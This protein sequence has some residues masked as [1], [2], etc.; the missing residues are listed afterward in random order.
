M[1]LALPTVHGLGNGAYEQWLWTHLRRVV[2]LRCAPELAICWGT[3]APAGARAVVYV[4]KDPQFLARPEVLHSLASAESAA[5]DV[6]VR[7]GSPAEVWLDVDVLSWFGWF[8][9]R[10]EEY[11]PHELDKHGRFPRAAALAQRLGLME[12]PVADLLALHLRAA[13]ETVAKATGLAI[14]PDLPWPDGKRFAVCLT[15]DVDRVNNRNLWLAG[16]ILAGSFVSL[17]QGRFRRA[18]R[19]LYAS[20]GLVRGSRH[21]PDWLFDSMAERE[22]RRGFRSAFYLLPHRS[23]FV[24]EGG[25]RVMRYDVGRPDVLGGFRRLA[26]GGWEIGH[27]ISYDA[28][29]LPNAL[30][31]EWARLK[32]ILGPQ[33]PLI[34]CRSHYLRFHTPETWLQQAA[35]GIRYDATLGWPEGSG[36]R[37]ST[38]HPYRAFDRR[39]GQVIP[40]WEL[41]MHLMD[42][43]PTLKALVSK[44]REVCD[45]VAEVGG[46]ACLLFHPTTPRLAE[47]TAREYLEAYDEILD[48]LASRKDCWVATPREV[49]EHMERPPRLRIPD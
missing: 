12:E 10:G 20:W 45:R 2:A 26:A 19:R 11:E 41:G 8:V 6:A 47:A 31:Q 28:H 1:L 17:L 33:V 25:H 4:P 18:R 34:G 24:S 42:T 15:H 32:G 9:S 39:G 49:V 38:C 21:S 40:V 14:A 35:Y 36:F 13:I 16:Q 46:C 7:P 43:F 29:G 3:P 48:D 37:S 5:A 27:H 23:N 22:A 30:G 44:T